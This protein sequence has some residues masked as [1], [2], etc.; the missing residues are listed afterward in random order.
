MHPDWGAVVNPCHHER[1]L[2]NRIDP[3]AIPSSSSPVRF[4][5]I[6]ME[7]VRHFKRK[8]QTGEEPA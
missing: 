2:L 6:S 5:Q 8:S 1:G 4:E 3:T 7:W